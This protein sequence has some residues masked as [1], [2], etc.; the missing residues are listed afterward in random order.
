MQVQGFSEDVNIKN[1]KVFWQKINEFSKTNVVENNLG[2]MY[3]MLQFAKEANIKLSE[4]YLNSLGRKIK[5]FPGVETWF[6]RINEF[7]RKNNAEIQ[8]YIISS[9]LRE[10]IE[11]TSISKQFKRIY[12]SSYYYENGEAKWPSWVVDY[13]NKTRYIFRIS[14]GKLELLDNSIN[15]S[16][17]P[18]DYQMPIKNIIY[19]GDSDT[20]IPCMALIKKN[21]GT[22]I[23]VYDKYSAETQEKLLKGNRINS[24]VKA[25]Y[26]ENSSLEDT[27]KKAILNIIKSAYTH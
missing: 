5:F 2:Y 22:S 25:D 13:T 12:A 8:H 9:G 7:G 24:Y 4:S 6:D 23:G 15:D 1:E 16:M 17:E 19:I 14:K 11:G 27:I 3:M 18:E 21:S 20:D 10:I 26:S